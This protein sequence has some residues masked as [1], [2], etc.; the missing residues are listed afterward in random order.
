MKYTLLLSVASSHSSFQK[1]IETIIKNIIEEQVKLIQGTANHMSK[2]KK[3]FT[4]DNHFTYIRQHSFEIRHLMFFLRNNQQYV[5]QLLTTIKQKEQQIQIAQL[6]ANSFYSNYLSSNSIEEEYLFILGR[7]LKYEIDNMETSNNP[8][9]FLSFSINS[10][11]LDHLVNRI[12]VKSFFIKLLKKIVATIDYNDDKRTITFDLNLINERIQEENMHFNDDNNGPPQSFEA[13]VDMDLNKVMDLQQT[14][15]VDSLCNNKK[16]P[17]TLKVGKEKF[18]NY[19]LPDLTR[20][21]IVSMIESQNTS[22]V[23][24]EYLSKQ[25]VEMKGKN[26]YFCNSQ[27]ITLLYSS[28]SPSDVLNKYYYNFANVIELIET[29]LDQMYLY[30]DMI[31]PSV[32][33]IAKIILHC[34]HKKFPNIAVVDRNAILSRFFFEKLMEPILLHLDINGLSHIISHSTQNTISIITKV[35]RKMVYANFFNI[36]EDPTFTTF[37]WFFIEKMPFIV[38]FF[39]KLTDIELPPLIMKALDCDEENN[40]KFIPKFDPNS[41]KYDYLKQNP[42][43]DV[44]NISICYTPIQLFIIVDTMLKNQN[45]FLNKNNKDEAQLEFI[46]GI[47]SISIDYIKELV[48]RDNTNQCDSYIY[49]NDYIYKKEISEI[50]NYNCNPSFS[51]QEI[52]DNENKN[53]VIK[54]KNFL[55]AVLTSFADIPKHNFFGTKIT[56]FESFLNSLSLCQSIQFNKIKDKTETYWNIQRLNSFIPKLDV[57]YKSNDYNKLFTELFQEVQTSMTNIKIKPVTHIKSLKDN[58]EIM[59]RE[60]NK[61]VKRINQVDFNHKILWFIE[62]TLVPTQIIITDKKEFEFKLKNKISKNI[63]KVERKSSLFR[64]KIIEKFNCQNINDFIKFFP[65]LNDYNDIVLKNR[66]QPLLKANSSEQ[67][68]VDLLSTT[69][70]DWN[71]TNVFTIADY[72]NIPKVFQDYLSMLITL[73]KQDKTVVNN[74]NDNKDFITNAKII[75]SE[76]IL[77][78]LYNKIFPSTQTDKDVT[79]NE[80]CNVLSTKQFSEYPGGIDIPIETLIPM[81]STLFE[82]LNEARNPCSKVQI[83]SKILD[84][85]NKQ[86]NLFLQNFEFDTYFAG[87]IYII[88][89]SKTKQLPSHIYYIKLYLEDASSSK[90]I[91]DFNSVMD[92]VFGAQEPNCQNLGI[93]LN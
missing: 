83:L 73:L 34:L 87:L 59:Y 28:N 68:N 2:S 17:D 65:N 43:E 50:N 72:F 18:F 51:L 40:N 31:P 78:K 55:C 7:T 3:G 22:V 41:F 19:Y 1:E 12:D 79:F 76:Y 33:Y 21:M 69:I 74:T 91:N 92:W 67:V 37:N 84:I 16:D 86:L 11:L 58:C 10:Y 80:K 29:I 60:L 71:S 14:F 5:Y 89:H 32:R 46:Q 82:S 8:N 4:L 48:N 24:G 15:F 63:D 13:S 38:N 75:I 26:N 81:T 88:V 90:I 61:I 54:T 44:Y 57:S 23:M 6:F 49:L 64:K 56:N 35:I 85:L 39:N 30:M 45:I 42:N 36:I 93:D 66:K 52:Q 70:L 62:N 47:E 53:I 77:N 9:E 25:L 20:K 27:F